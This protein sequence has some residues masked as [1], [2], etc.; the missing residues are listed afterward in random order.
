MGKI[1]DALEKHSKE[2]VI[3]S[4]P[5]TINKRPKR[6]ET[7]DLETSFARE[8]CQIQNCNNKLVVL[9]EPD[10]LDAQNF[11]ILRARILFSKDRERPKTIMVTSTLPGEGK[12]FVTTNLAASFALGID[13][14]VLLVDADLRR[15]SVHNM[16]GYEN[17]KGLK[18]Y[19]NGDK[20]LQDL[21]IRTEIEKLSVLT[22]GKVPP[23]PS[24]LL[25]SFKMESFLKEV[26]DRYSDRHIIVDS[27]PSMATAEASVL[28]RHV[29][30]II[31]VI[32]AHKAN[33]ESIKK[34]IQN[35]EAEKIFGIVFNGYT[36]AHKD[37]HKYYQ[38]YYVTN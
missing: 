35:L 19:L 22:A 7:K 31:F 6:L 15:P 27:S 16:L 29:D 23:N 21:I 33:R 24:E 14:Y 28:S 32:M 2:S 37:Y 10:S 18:D 8:Y 20:P 34:T 17:Y 26:K 5:S 12:T 30:G 4:D 1:F 25:S 38:G 3:S 36:K 9:S 11:K 13:E